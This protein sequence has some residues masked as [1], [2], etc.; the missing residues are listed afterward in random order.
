MYQRT[1]GFVAGQAGAAAVEFALCL[2]P[3]LLIVAGIVDFGE[4]W[5]MQSVLASASREGALT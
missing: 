1:K 5:Y 4:S 3:L 2:I